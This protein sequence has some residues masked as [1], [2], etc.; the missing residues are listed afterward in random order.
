MEYQAKN[1]LLNTT[2]EGCS[3]T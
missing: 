3:C 1:R 2:C